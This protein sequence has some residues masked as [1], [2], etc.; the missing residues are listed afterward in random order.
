MEGETMKSVITGA[1]GASI[2]ALSVLCGN[3]VYNK[4]QEIEFMKELIVEHEEK[5]D[6]LAEMLMQMLGYGEE[7]RGN[8]I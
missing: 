5:I 3:A 2:L 1:L 7:D 8:S 4:H 6:I